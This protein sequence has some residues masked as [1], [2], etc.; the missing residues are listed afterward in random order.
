MAP[1][2]TFKIFVILLMF[3]TFSYEFLGV[4][5]RFLSFILQSQMRLFIDIMS[6]EAHWHRIQQN[7]RLLKFRRCVETNFKKSPSS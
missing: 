3:F 7:F 1:W 6:I 5:L 2:N 4:G